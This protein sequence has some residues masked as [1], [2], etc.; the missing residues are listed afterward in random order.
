MK[1]KK[2]LKNL[3]SNPEILGILFIGCI[4]LCLFIYFSFQTQTKLNE[5]STSLK[6]NSST[7][8]SKGEQRPYSNSIEEDLEQPNYLPSPQVDTENLSFYS[9]V[10]GFDFNK[11]IES[12]NAQKESINGISYAAASLES[13]GNIRF[14]QNFINNINILNQNLSSWELN[15]HSSDTNLMNEFLKL[16]VNADT[17]KANLGTLILENPKLNIINL[18]I[19]SLSS[20]SKKRFLNFLS[21]TKKFLN[22]QNIL[23]FLTIFPAPENIQSYLTIKQSSEYIDYLNRTDKLILML[24]DYSIHFKA[25]SQLSPIFWHEQLIKSLLNLDIELRSKLAIALPLYA[26]EFG[27]DT[28]LIN[29]AKTHQQLDLQ[30]VEVTSKDNESFYINSSG[31]K[32]VFLSLNN[33]KKLITEYSSIGIDAFYFWRLGGDEDMLSQL[34]VQT[35][36]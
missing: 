35:V 30:S 27:N 34:K 14:S 8:E 36:P 9:W 21:E 1:N 4:L 10:P 31:G 16:Q 6:I 3:M 12:Y 11:G 24:Y 22:S 28:G 18:N 7:N 25:T 5:R 17:F 13:S 29:Y 20:S 33:L 32:V 19:E 26:Y 23:L 2:K 15:I